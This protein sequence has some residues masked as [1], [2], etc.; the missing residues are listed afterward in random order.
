MFGPR[1]SGVAAL[2]ECDKSGPCDPQEFPLGVLLLNNPGYTIAGELIRANERMEE[3]MR[4]GGGV[5][6][7]TSEC[8]RSS[9]SPL[10]PCCLAVSPSACLFLCPSSLQIERLS[11]KGCDYIDLV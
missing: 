1:G 6:T 2:A 5:H 7:Q 8:N 4:G 3:E 9:L 10:L 11:D